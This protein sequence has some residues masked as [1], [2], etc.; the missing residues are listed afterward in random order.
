MY[1]A[2]RVIVVDESTLKLSKGFIIQYISVYA[3][4]PSY[5]FK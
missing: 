4:K 1:G 3:K 5:I 2:L